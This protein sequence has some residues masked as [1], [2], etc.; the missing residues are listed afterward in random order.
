MK[1]IFTSVLC[2]LFLMGLWQC[3]VTQDKKIEGKIVRIFGK[4][5]VNGQYA[6]IGQIVKKGDFVKTANDEK[7]F[8][9][10]KFADYHIRL[11]K[12]EM[13]IQ[14]SG[15]Y[16]IFNLFDGKLYSAVKKLA[17]KNSFRVETSTAV[18]GVRGTKFFTQAYPSKTYVCV[19]EGIV[20]GYRK[21]D[22][23]I[24]KDILRGYDLYLEADKSLE[25]PIESPDMVKMIV[26][27]FK[28]M[29]LAVVE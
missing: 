3:S 10:I 22:P 25:N 29:G 21:D 13:K 24:Q 23:Q 11:K 6:K 5:L 8:A 9:D 14:S 28:D 15:K 4:V 12:G 26:G 20:Y 2:L 16:P 19:C 1:R 27:E 7:S 18:L 17:K